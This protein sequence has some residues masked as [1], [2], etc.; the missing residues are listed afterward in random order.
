L[1]T[2]AQPQI[3]DVDVEFNGYRE[4]ENG[5]VRTPPESGSTKDI[6]LANQV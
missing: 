3:S 2:V 4:E 5:G 1:G 6:C